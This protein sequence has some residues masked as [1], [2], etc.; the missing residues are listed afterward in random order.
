MKRSLLVVAAALFVAACGGADDT[1]TTTAGQTTTSSS[2]TST[3]EAAG[4][5]VNIV[6]L[7]FRPGDL[8]VAVGS[9]VTWTNGDGPDHTTSSDDDAWDSG[10][11][12]TGET[13]S[14]VFDTPGIF[15]YHCNIHPRM[16][17]TVTVEG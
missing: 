6:N 11:L 5:Q 13:F 4:D 7:S 8:T 17:A 10:V 1:T 15:E 2:T 9:E 14:V 3:T 12:A 16:T